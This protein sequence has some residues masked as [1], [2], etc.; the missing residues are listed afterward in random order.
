MQSKKHASAPDKASEDF[1]E[2]FSVLDASA[3]LFPRKT[4]AEPSQ[5]GEWVTVHT[6]S[7]VVTNKVVK[8]LN[9]LP[10]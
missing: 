2:S 8:Q 1:F 3:S 9:C 10:L 6:C 4:L 7:I 5:Q